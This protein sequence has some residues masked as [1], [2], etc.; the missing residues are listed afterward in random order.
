[1]GVTKSNTL[2]DTKLLKFRKMIKILFRK[3]FNI[4]K[5]EI[6]IIQYHITEYDR[7]IFLICQFIDSI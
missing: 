1:M 3:E 2:Y 7:I 4:K 6:I 5:E